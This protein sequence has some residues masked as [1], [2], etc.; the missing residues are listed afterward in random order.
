MIAGSLKDKTVLITGG[1]GGIGFELAKLFLKEE[2]RLILVASR[3][4]K[5]EAA[6]AFLQKEFKTRPVLIA[7]DLSKPSAPWEIFSELSDKKISVDVL[8]N[9]AGVGVYGELEKMDPD[10]LLQMV[11]LNIRSVV[12]LTRFFT[13]SMVQ[14]GSG[15]ILNVAS[16]AAF[17]A[18][19]R[20]A[21][22]AASKTFVLHFSEALAEEL[23]GSGV[24]VT[25]L[26]PGPTDTDFFGDDKMRLSA[27]LR[28]NMMK[29]DDV[30]RAGFE[31]L[32]RGDRIAVPGL[33]NKVVKALAK[34]APRKWATK[35]AG[36]VV[37]S[38]EL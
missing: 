29:S 25:C 12:A 10:R 35:I 20:E 4:E 22:Y 19:P 32:K 26:C 37:K 15:G 17:Q 14:R 1:S 5:L 36:R 6:G 31:A 34:L 7:K 21:V 13:P 8:V 16:T 23:R 30:A 3:K 38:W 24:S 2:A 28:K 27:A 11:D 18:I 33:V 9:N